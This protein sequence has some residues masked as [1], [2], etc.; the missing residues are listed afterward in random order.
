V[1]TLTI[2][3]QTLARLRAAAAARNV[4]LEAYIEEMAKVDADGKRDSSAKA[5]AQ[6]RK[7]TAAAAA[8][9]QKLASKVKN[10]ATIEELIADKHSHRVAGSG[11]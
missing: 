8:S 10:K 6:F 4:S 1:A 9:I 2:P 3:D 11:T 7:S 5:L